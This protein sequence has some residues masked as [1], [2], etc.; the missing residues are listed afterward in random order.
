MCHINWEICQYFE[1]EHLKILYLHKGN[2][3]SDVACS[4]NPQQASVGGLT[5]YCFQIGIQ[6]CNYKVV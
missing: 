4:S 3:A 2:Q 6:H 1:V 5:Q